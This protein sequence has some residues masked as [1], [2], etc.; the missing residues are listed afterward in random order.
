[1]QR[2]A[3]KCRACDRLGEWLG[4]QSWAKEDV[5]EQWMVDTRYSLGGIVIAGGYGVR[6]RVSGMVYEDFQI[7]LTLYGQTTGRRGELGQK[8]VRRQYVIVPCLYKRIS[9]KAFKYMKVFQYCA[10]F[11]FYYALLLQ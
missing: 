5:N 1:M 10:I 4:A 3:Q 6:R 7:V 8:K 9:V 2:H 11:D